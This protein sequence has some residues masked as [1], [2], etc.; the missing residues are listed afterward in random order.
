[1]GKA[2]L[3]RLHLEWGRESPPQKRKTA[4][5][6]PTAKKARRD[7]ETP[8]SASVATGKKSVE[9][10]CLQ[11]AEQVANVSPS[12][13]LAKGKRPSENTGGSQA[14]TGNA[15]EW[16]AKDATRAIKHALKKAPR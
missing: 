9:D 14:A 16:N 2:L 13:P 1:M 11:R 8:C 10:A 15:E 3:D 4:G 5:D 7:E 12:Y 6:L